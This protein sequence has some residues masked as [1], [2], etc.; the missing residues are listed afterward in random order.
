MQKNY[1]IKFIDA[2]GDLRTIN[3]KSLSIY[4]LLETFKSEYG[5]LS[6]I[7]SIEETT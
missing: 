3:L 4:M 1:R 5:C 2:W 6:V 7:K